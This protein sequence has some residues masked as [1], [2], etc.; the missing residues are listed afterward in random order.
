MKRI[1]AILTAA[2]ALAS[3]AHAA[4]RNNSF[5][6]SQVTY[7]FGTIKEMG[8][9]VSHT[10]IYTNHGKKAVAIA[11]ATTH[12]EC[13]KVT[14]SKAPVKP[15]ASTRITVT[16]EP[17][18]HP[19][20]FSKAIDIRLS[21][22]SHAK[23]CRIAGKVLEAKLTTEQRFPYDL[24]GGLRADMQQLDFRGATQGSKSSLFIRLINTGKKPLYLRFSTLPALSDV[25]VPPTCY[26]RPGAETLMAVSV[27]PSAATRR[28]STVS[29]IPRV[30]GKK[31]KTI[32]ML[33]PKR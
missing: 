29:I 18:A 10:F 9:P 6:P 7:N 4:V 27:T 2:I 12:C 1:I 24:T 21:D 33:M 13:A 19:G 11:N 25:E 22:G 5:S 26:L 20:M 28:H 8:G 16:F 23:Q 32:T 30:N 17:K 14:F 31:L 3:S 15:G